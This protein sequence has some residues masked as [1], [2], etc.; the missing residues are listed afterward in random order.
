MINHMILYEDIYL[1][2]TA[3]LTLAFLIVSFI[4]KINGF[5]M[6]LSLYGMPHPLSLQ[7]FVVDGVQ[8]YYAR[9]VRENI[10]LAKLGPGSPEQ[11]KV[12]HHSALAD[13]K[14]Q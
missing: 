1:C 13:L 6:M 8:I 4:P 12:S 14:N 11:Q 10:K 7:V 9:L 2:F 5:Q 3:L